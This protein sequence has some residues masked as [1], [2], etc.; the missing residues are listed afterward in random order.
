MLQIEEAYEVDEIVYL[1]SKGKESYFKAKLEKGQ[2]VEV[3][4]STKKPEVPLG[5]KFLTKKETDEVAEKLKYGVTASV[6]NAAI[7]E[8]LEEAT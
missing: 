8:L 5:A 6:V 3:D 7:I 4:K 1:V 2:V